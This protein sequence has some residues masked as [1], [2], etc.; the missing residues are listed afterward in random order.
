MKKC[1]TA[2]I[3]TLLVYGCHIQI[4]VNQ[5]LHFTYKMYCNMYEH[6]SIFTV[7]K[8]KHNDYKT[9]DSPL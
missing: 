7:P 3:S 4:H 1:V 2:G 9:V 8:F 5:M 6:Y